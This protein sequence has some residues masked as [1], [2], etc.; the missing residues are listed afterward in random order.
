MVRTEE[1]R[2][3]LRNEGLMEVRT[4]KNCSDF[5]PLFGFSRESWGAH[6]DTWMRWLVKV[7]DGKK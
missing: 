1:R 2:G 4:G 3:C 7:L 5:N 6:R